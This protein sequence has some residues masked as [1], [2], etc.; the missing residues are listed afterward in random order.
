MPSRAKKAAKRRSS[1]NPDVVLL[2]M[3]LPMMNGVEVIKELK[4]S[5]ATRDIPIIVMT[6]Y[7]AEANFFESEIKT[8]GSIE[9]LRK[10]VQMEE[11]VKSIK[12]ILRNRDGSPPFAIWKRGTMRIIPDSKSI[13]IG[14]R[15]IANLAPKRFEVLFHLMQSHGEVPGAGPRRQNMGK[16]RDEERSGED[17]S[18]LARGSRP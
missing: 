15:M 4:K 3:M 7:P 13:W 12:R 6:A 11:L 18:A 14:E 17:D 5:K 16:G 10:P 9:Y 2:D 1:L 8:F